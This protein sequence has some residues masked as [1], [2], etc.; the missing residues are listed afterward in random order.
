LYITG[1]GESSLTTHGYMVLGSVTGGNMV[2]DPN[3]IQARS[4]GAATTLRLQ[5]D[6]GALL[7]QGGALT[8]A[9]NGN[10]GIGDLTPDE[11]L[12]VQ[13]N[14]LFDGTNPTIQLQNSGVNKG[15]FQLSG[16]N[17]RTGTNNGNGTGKFIFR[18]N[19]TDRI[20]IDPSGNMGIGI[21][22][23]TRKLHV[24]GNG[25]FKSNDQALAID[26]VN[27]HIAFYHNSV[28][29]SF[30]QQSSAKLHIGVNGGKLQLDANQIAIGSVQT[31][32]DNFKLAVTGKIICEELKVEL[33]ANWPDYVFASDY[34]LTPLSELKA[35]IDQHQHLPNIP[36]AS[37]VQKDG[38]EVGEMNRRLLEKVEELTLYIIQQ[39]E[40][41]DMLAKKLEVIEMQ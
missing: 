36:K 8:V 21:D 10:V 11:A 26:G 5:Q 41:I 40:Q 2:L 28:Y 31:T 30:I 34:K 7:V 33:V 19:G 24:E 39:Q 3:E 29:K 13:G 15:Y 32:A 12:H 16:D 38:F 23:P 22:A 14:G 18:I 20:F 25:Y 17:V 27:P 37:E 6:G 1:G 9:T 35:F 4:N